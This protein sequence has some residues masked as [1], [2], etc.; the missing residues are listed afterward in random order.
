MTIISVNEIETEIEI[1]FKTEIT[2]YVCDDCGSHP[3]LLT[4]DILV[5]H[6]ICSIH[7]VI[8]HSKPDKKNSTIFISISGMEKL[9]NV[10]F[11]ARY[12]SHVKS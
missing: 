3:E 12:L 11:T 7:L 9:E 5:W 10:I 2:L 6:I 4:E 1:H 8:R